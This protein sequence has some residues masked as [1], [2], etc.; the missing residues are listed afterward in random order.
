M[1]IIKSNFWAYLI[2]IVFILSISESWFLC[3]YIN[4]F[5]PLFVE[6][7]FTILSV[8][9]KASNSKIETSFEVQL[10]NRMQRYL[11]ACAHRNYLES[12]H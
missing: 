5:D 1:Q 4:Y 9:K 2:I 11:E 10:N 8:L 3:V 12:V 7:V 6:I